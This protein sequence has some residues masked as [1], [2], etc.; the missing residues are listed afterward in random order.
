MTL[1]SDIRKLA[2]EFTPYLGGIIT[3]KQV[4]SA[5]L[6]GI[7]LVLKQEAS[8]EMRTIG[9]KKLDAGI[10]AEFIYYAMNAQRLKELDNG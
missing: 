2:E 3:V 5:I 9:E 8:E 1:R 7:R 4:E 6:A 10:D